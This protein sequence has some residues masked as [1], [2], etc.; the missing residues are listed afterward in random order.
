MGFGSNLFKKKELAKPKS[1]K[2]GDKGYVRKQGT[3]P[4]LKKEPIEINL[5]ALKC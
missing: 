1:K 4:V 3:K 2:I 5:S